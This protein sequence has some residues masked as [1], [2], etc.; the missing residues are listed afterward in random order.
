MCASLCKP[1]Q[2]DTQNVPV[3]PA[4]NFVFDHEKE[5]AIKDITDFLSEKH[6]GYC[7]GMAKLLKSGSIESL[8]RKISEIE[9]E[10]TTQQKP[11]SGN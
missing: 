8:A 4:E 2:K 11:D 6:T 5:R 3:N 1:L 7:V 9:N 10:N